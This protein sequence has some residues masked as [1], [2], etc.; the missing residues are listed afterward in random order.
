MITE[1]RK[2]L[3]AGAQPIFDAQIAAVTRVQRLPP[4]WSEI[5]FYRMRRGRPDWSGVPMFPCTD[6]LRLAEVRFQVAA[7]RYKAT[8]CSIDGHI[9]DFS[10]TPSP[11][12]IAFAAWDGEPKVVLLGDPLQAPTGRR[13]P[14]KLPVVW[15]KLLESGA[16]QAAWVLHDET[17]AYR[18]TLHDGVYVV[19]GEREG[20]E[21]ILYRI[22]PPAEQ[23]FHLRHHDCTPERLR[24]EI[25]DVL[26]E[27][28]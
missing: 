6:E 8:L 13:E 3:P 17:T 14:E 19:L 22:D 11:K 2:V 27:G 12:G 15:R 21:F 4:W 1:V 28:A 25:A 10:I 18:V 24:G 20:D 9:F 5:S 16:R 26:G 7:G 23:L